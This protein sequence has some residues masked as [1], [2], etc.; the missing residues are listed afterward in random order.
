LVYKLW[1]EENDKAFGEGPYKLLKG[2]CRLGSLNKTVED[3]GISYS[4]AWNIIKR[5]EEQLGFLL[6]ERRTGGAMGGGCTLT[7]E[8]IELIKNYEK[9]KI[10]VDK[11]L[12]VL[13]QQYLESIFE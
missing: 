2:I 9:F 3:M 6:L 10:E 5:S 11:A 12:K 4:K 8:A 1:L 13:Y 7:S